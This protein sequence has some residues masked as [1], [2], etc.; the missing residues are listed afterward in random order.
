MIG[1]LSL[2]SYHFMPYSL[3]VFT[4]SML[5]YYKK[6]KKYGE[7]FDQYYNFLLSNGLK[8]QEQKAEE[9]L[10][11]FLKYI[12]KNCP[13]YAQYLTNN[14]NLKD[15][16]II[17]KG[18]VNKQYSDFLLSS[19]F[20]VGKSSGTTG[21]PLKVP[22]SK[23]V[24]QKEYAFWWYHRS[25]GGVNRGDK[26]ATFGGH[27]IADVNRDKPPFWVYNAAERQM[28][29]SS[30]HLSKKNLPYYIRTLNRY[31]PDFI[32]GYPSSLYYVAKYIIDENVQLNFKPNMVVGS[33]ETTLDFQ[34]NTIEQAFKTK[35]YVWYGNTEFCGHITECSYGKLHIQ[36]YHSFV[37]ILKK[38]NTDAKPGETGRIVATNFTNYSF[39]FINY[40]I[41]DIVKISQDQNCPCDKGGTVLDYIL[42]RVEDYI[43][44]PEGRFVG[45]LDHLFKDAKHVKNG[46][47]VQNDINN[48]I[49]R[50]EK[51]NGFTDKIEK[52]ILHEAR[53]RLGNTIE[54][55]FEYVKEMEREPNGKLKFVVQNINPERFS[56]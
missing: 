11:E 38:D 16:P 7:F 26:I 19:P 40:D 25:F 12:K 4:T 33:S 41:K 9:E 53:V 17:D 23:N 55:Q 52:A 22:Y 18:I 10:E 29:F 5:A 50:I 1:D 20:F 28:F 15:L 43:I 39:A 37:R 2:I 21:Q 14:Y 31:R 36:P 48:I 32:H 35:L 49:I 54:I 8:H 56:H 27:K 34:R 3:K 46:Q 24:Y 42:G 45:R 30:Y 6:K 51:E 47:I 13:F 44:T